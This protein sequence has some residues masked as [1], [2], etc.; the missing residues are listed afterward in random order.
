MDYSFLMFPGFREKAV[1]LS[2]DD[3]GDADRR[4]VAILN[5]H[6]LKGTFNLNSKM[7]Y[8]QREG[9]LHADE[10]KNLYLTAGHEIATH[11]CVHLPL[12]AVD[13]AS[14]VNDI[15]NYRKALEILS[16]DFVIGNA[17]ADGS[18]DEDVLR[19]MKY[20][21]ICYA[22]TTTS[23]YSFNMPREWLKWNPTCKHTDPKLME[24]AKEFVEWQP[25]SYYLNNVPKL[26]YLWGHSFEF[27]NDDNWNVI[28]EFSAYIGGREDIWYATNNEIFKYAQAFER[29]Q[30]SANGE[31][32]YNPSVVDVYIR[33]F[34]KQYLVPAGKKVILEGRF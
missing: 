24:L 26:F 11:G 27:D 12:A 28:E 14:A 23:T 30:F 25:R 31:M 21:G 5:K 3:G 1:T 19:I 22:R 10:V 34:G 29:L 16:G 2:Y 18:Y 15:I 13:F 7:V 17:Y 4:L 32:V 33:Y 9:K 8:S 6:G 20:C